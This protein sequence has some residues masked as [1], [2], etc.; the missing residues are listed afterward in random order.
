MK[1]E[2][3]GI[4]LCKVKMLIIGIV[5]IGTH[6]LSRIECDDW[7]HAPFSGNWVLV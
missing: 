1:K 6:E 4:E 7:E 2:G 5:G 3:L